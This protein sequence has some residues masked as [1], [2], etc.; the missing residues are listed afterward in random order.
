[1][2][3][4]HGR[5]SASLLTAI[6]LAGA[7]AIVA[8]SAGVGTGAGVG[9]GLAAA[10]AVLAALAGFRTPAARP[11]GSSAADARGGWLEVQRELDRARRHDRRF[12]LIRMPAAGG[13]E[14][15]N[16]HA[17]GTAGA[18]SL[19]RFLRP[20]LRSIDSLWVSDGYL[21]VLLPESNRSMGEAFLARVRQSDPCA[22][23]KAD[24][25]GF[26]ED[27]VTA[28]AL[29]ALLNGRSVARYSAPFIPD[30]GRIAGE[31]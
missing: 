12:T 29:F 23:P 13:G 22:V 1:M 25:V 16:G 28:G 11:E 6:A 5:H 30:A 24:L 21:Y 31:S 26:P 4:A 19:G 18:E 27:G 10:A 15:G 8:W 20:F 3:N 17:P 2:Q 7:G 9:V 14:S